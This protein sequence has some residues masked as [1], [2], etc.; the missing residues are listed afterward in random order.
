MTWAL[1]F[2]HGPTLRRTM[3]SSPTSAAP[4]GHTNTHWVVL[5]I[6]IALSHRLPF[7]PQSSCDRGRADGVI[8]SFH[9]GRHSMTL[10]LSMAECRPVHSQ[11]RTLSR[12]QR[13]Y[14]VRLGSG[15]KSS[16]A[17]F[18]PGPPKASLSHGFTIVFPT[19]TYAI[20]LFKPSLAHSH[21][22][23]SFIHKDWLSFS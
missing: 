1:N 17:F 12:A 14:E 5:G 6:C 8:S 7:S 13:G 3:L 11:L 10:E 22:S 15:N 9:L 23:Q 18:P 19:K 20:S 2:C 21:L 4:P 16:W